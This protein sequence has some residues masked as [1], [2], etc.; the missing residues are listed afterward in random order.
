[1]V[2]VLVLVLMLVGEGGGVFR[3]SKNPSHRH[4]QLQL[5][6]SSISTLQTGHP[7][8]SRAPLDTPEAGGLAKGLF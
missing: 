1:M 8:P 6:L 2:S 5:G 7:S 3:R 4:Y